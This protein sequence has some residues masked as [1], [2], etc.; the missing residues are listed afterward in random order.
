MKKTLLILTS[1]LLSFSL[2]GCALQERLT[3][4]TSKTGTADTDAATGASQTETADSQYI[5]GVISSVDDE[6]K[7]DLVETPE[8][9][10]LMSME[11][12]GNGFRKGQDFGMEPGMGG[13]FRKGPHAGQDSEDDSTVSPSPEGNNEQQKN[14]TPPALN[15]GTTNT[16]SPSEG[17]TPPDLNEGSAPSLPFQDSDEAPSMPAPPDGTELPENGQMPA[18]S[19]P[20]ASSQ[21]GSGETGQ[22]NRKA[23]RPGNGTEGQH[24]NRPA[25]G[26][27][28]SQNGKGSIDTSALTKTGD[29]LS[30]DPDE[31]KIKRQESGG[32]STIKAE[33]LSEGDLVKI[34]YKDG[35]VSELVVVT[36]N[37]FQ[38]IKNEVPSNVP[39]TGNGDLV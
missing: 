11:N 3:F 6:I 28:G 31:I 23:M 30:V 37:S 27:P 38:Q 29:T 21:E 4:T 14:S 9:S 20:S 8:G 33:A 5:Y 15:D 7:I 39:E 13:E 16:P 2:F 10:A 18:P 24:D 22:D 36:I 19:D 1:A 32:T 26:P 35:N 25:G 17:M 12:E 34:V